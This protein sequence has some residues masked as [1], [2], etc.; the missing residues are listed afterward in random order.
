M[1]KLLIALLVV[2]TAVAHVPIIT[3]S[4][5]VREQRPPQIEPEPLPLVVFQHPIT[6]VP[7]IFLPW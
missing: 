1:K 3:P 6:Q 2:G 4:G 7:I 5:E